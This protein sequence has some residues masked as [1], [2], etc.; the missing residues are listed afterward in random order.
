MRQQK[1][2]PNGVACISRKSENRITKLMTN[3]DNNKKH[4]QHKRMQR[5]Y[6]GHLKKHLIKY[7]I[8][9]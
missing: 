7:G 5:A 1:H 8:K 4:Q 3:R 2:N 9:A 6:D